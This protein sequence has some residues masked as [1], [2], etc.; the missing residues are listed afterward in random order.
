[1]G[2]HQ[3]KNKRSSLDYHDRYLPIEGFADLP[4]LPLE[5]AVEPLIPHLPSIQTYVR[6]AKDKC[7]HPAHHLT[8]D[9]SASIMLCTMRWQPIEQCLSYVLNKILRST[10][11]EKLKPWFS[12]LKLLFTALDRIPSFH[13]TVYRGI[14]SNVSRQYVKDQTIIWWDF[15]LCTT[16]IDRLYSEKYLNRKHSRTILT[17][18]CYSSKDIS[19]HTYDPSMEFIL[20]LPATQLRVIRCVQQKPNIHWIRLTEIRSPFVLLQ[21]ISEY[22]PVSTSSICMYFE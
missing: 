5:L 22:L 8:C 20:L 1:M 17:I 4:I 7:L 6:Q 11:R 21:S 3:D 10:D 14:Q 19:Q 12:Y 2:A 13:R 9:Q 15:S 18:E 16:T